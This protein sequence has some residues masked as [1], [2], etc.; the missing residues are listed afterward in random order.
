MSTP[1]QYKEAT[2]LEDVRIQQLA[3]SP[4]GI[5]QLKYDGIWA[6]VVV[7][8]SAAYV[9]S[10]TEVCKEVF[11]REPRLSFDQP[12]PC[13]L[14][15]EY[16]FGSQWSQHPERKGQ[17]YVFDCTA[18]D[19]ASLEHLPYS[20]R[21]RT[22]LRLLPQLDPRFLCTPCYPAAKFGLLWTDIVEK[23]SYEG[24]IFRRW[25]DTY[26]APL[27]KLKREV[28]DDFVILGMTEGE[29]KH[30]G[31]MGSLQVGQIDPDTGDMV[32]VMDVGGGF[33]DG[34]RERFWHNEVAF[35][36]QVILVGSKG[37][38][39]SGALRHP[40]FI[41]FRTDKPPLECILKRQSKST[42]E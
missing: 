38:F 9:Y 4:D 33:S 32:Y 16:M 29:G 23:E 19:G 17:F 14:I 41:R 1:Q 35:R 8:G 28:E 12:P 5:V 11:T 37:R 25:S 36:G 22:A 27:L 15:C 26:A 42:T 20:E 40:N 10:K 18:L 6:K 2:S 7:N 3:N 31:R 34:D 24:L 30:K 21:Y 13:T 39:D